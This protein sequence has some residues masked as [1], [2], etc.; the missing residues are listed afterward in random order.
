MAPKSSFSACRLPFVDLE[1][2]IKLVLGG[3]TLELV[4]LRYGVVVD[5]VDAELDV[6]E[7]WTGCA[8]SVGEPERLPS[9]FAS[10]EVYMFVAVVVGGRRARCRSHQGQR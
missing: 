2:V 10:V 8:C 5:T 4:E 7:P 6:L 1:G 3:A 9:Q